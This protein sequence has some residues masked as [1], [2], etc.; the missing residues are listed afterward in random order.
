MALQK[1]NPH[2]T[3][4][5]Q[6][7]VFSLTELQQQLDTDTLLLEYEL[8]SDHSY[9]WLISKTEVKSF[10]LPKRSEIESKVK[11][12]RDLL[13]ARNLL[14]RGQNIGGRPIS[15]DLAEN[16]YPK[17]AIEVS[18]L[19]LSPIAD[20]LAEKRLVIV[21]DGAIEYIPFNAL[22]DPN[23]TDIYEPLILK[24]EI[25]SLPSASTINTLRK[26]AKETFQIFQKLNLFHMI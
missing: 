20:Q 10:F 23:K 22:P 17:I 13:V 12:L 4:F 8:G 2:Y 11:Y 14:A 3:E 1:Q 15:L 16:E 7:K 6:P 25:V 24:H 5:A 21:T 19:L 9:L 18:K 26:E